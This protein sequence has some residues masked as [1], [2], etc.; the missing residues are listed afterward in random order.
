MTDYRFQLNEQAQRYEALDDDQV[1]GVIEYTKDGNVY[2]F[3][4]T[5]T[6]DAY[7]GKGVAGGLTEFALKDLQA[8]N[9]QVV[10]VC[11]Y[12]AAYIA[13]H[14]QFQPLVHHKLPDASAR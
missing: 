10:P 8:K 7:R 2:T 1:A 3:E 4:H 12:A 14:E 11:S 13:K 6:A 9:A 5:V